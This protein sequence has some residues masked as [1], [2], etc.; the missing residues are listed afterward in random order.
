MKPPKEWPSNASE[1]LIEELTHFNPA[2][3]FTDNYFRINFVCPSCGNTELCQIETVNLI[4]PI[5]ETW[6]EGDGYEF[7]L[8]AHDRVDYGTSEFLTFM[9]DRCGFEPANC[10]DDLFKWLLSN[11]MLERF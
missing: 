1:R 11:G 7:E 3:N 6:A 9:C 8:S 5:T 4:T 2:E 10:G